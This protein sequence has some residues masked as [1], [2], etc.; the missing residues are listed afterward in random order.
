MARSFLEYAPPHK[1]LR[2][3]SLPQWGWLVA[4]L[5]FPIGPFIALA[6]AK[7]LSWPKAIVLAVISY[8]TGAAMVLLLIYLQNSPNFQGRQF[9]SA[10]VPISLFLGWGIVIYRIGRAADYWCPRTRR[11]C[12]ILLWIAVSLLLVDLALPLLVIFVAPH[13]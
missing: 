4:Y 1:P 6:A 3:S 12:L 7:L 11:I 9:V 2:G 5:F 8:G 13:H 10:L